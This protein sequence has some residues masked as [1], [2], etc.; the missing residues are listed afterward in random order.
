MTA[1]SSAVCLYLKSTSRDCASAVSSKSATSTRMSLLAGPNRAT[2]Q[3]PK[4]SVRTFADLSIVIAKRSSSGEWTPR[5][6]RAWVISPNAHSASVWSAKIRSKGT[7]R[8]GGSW[9][10]GSARMALNS[11]SFTWANVRTQ[12]SRGFC[13][14]RVPISSH[15][16]GMRNLRHLKT[17]FK[18]SKYGANAQQYSNAPKARKRTKRAHLHQ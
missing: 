13:N 6:A 7:P 4:S 17:Q 18:R 14:F 15:S 8:T 11:S 5:A 1:A 9:T 3:G 12:P 2:S 16:T 10:I